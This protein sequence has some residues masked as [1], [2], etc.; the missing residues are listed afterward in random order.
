[1]PIKYLE[2][3]PWHKRQATLLYHFASIE[4][5]KGLLPQIDDLIAFTDRLLDERGKFDAYGRAE[6]G[7]KPASTAG[8]FST[9]AYPAL[10]DFREGVV[11]DIALRAFERYSTAGEDFC[12]R[13]LSEY[14]PYMIWATH[15][16]EAEFKQRTDAV[17]NY[18]GMISRIMARPTVVKDF[19]FWTWWKKYKDSSK[20][21]PRFRVRPDVEGVTDAAPPRTGVYV[22]QGDPYGALQFAWTGG[23]GELGRT[24][25]FNKFGLEALKK[26]GRQG[27]WEDQ[28]GLIE[29]LRDNKYK[30]LPN[31]FDIDREDAS[32]APSAVARA[33]FESKPCKWYFVEMVNDE[34]EEIDGT[35]AGQAEAV[36]NSVS[37]PERVPGGEPVPQAGWWHTPA[38]AGS[39]RYF[40]Q[41]D[42]FPVIEDSD[43]G[44]TF[45]LWSPDQSSPTLR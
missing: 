5:L 7:W 37:R 15:E 42:T 33:G 38:K 24:Y 18:A 16:Q 32:L 14:A 23:Y 20:K 8:N 31:V 10:V 17:F 45:W 4:Y 13:M 28:N 29:L 40:K 43:Y 36:P 26:V 19:A 39:R 44:S 11:K 41:G 2:L 6:L 12:A 9:Y 30:D 25:T 21:I 3:N 34:Y 22:P 27:L 35:Y 1:M